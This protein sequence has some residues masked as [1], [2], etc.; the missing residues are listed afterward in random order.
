[1]RGDAQ[2]LGTQGAVRRLQQWSIRRGVS[3]FGLLHCAAPC[4][5]LAWATP[6]GTADDGNLIIS[7][8]PVRPL[9]H[10]FF[11]DPR[12]GTDPGAS[13]H[14]GPARVF[15]QATEGGRIAIA[16]HVDN[17]TKLPEPAKP[18]AAVPRYPAAC[19]QTIGGRRVA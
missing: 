3:G 12:L 14:F 19:R 15:D 2:D 5:L 11:W 7:G 18:V 4:Q 13:K 10:P 6:L 16:G 1:M 9:C 17:L 8:P